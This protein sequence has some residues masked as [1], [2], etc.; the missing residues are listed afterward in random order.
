MR[1]GLTGLEIRLKVET[2]KNSSNFAGIQTSS[3][4]LLVKSRESDDLIECE[5]S[6]VASRKNRRYEI[7]RYC[8]QSRFLSNRNA[9][10]DHNYRKGKMKEQR[11]EE[12]VSKRR[13]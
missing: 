2:E 7:P 4:L 9:R 10:D 6:E 11:G 13:R 5:Y 3:I 8:S 12:S 1:K